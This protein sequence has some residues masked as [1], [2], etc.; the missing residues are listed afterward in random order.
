MKKII[1]DT[2]F[3]VSCAEFKVDLF[4]EFE[5]ICDFSFELFIVDKSLVEL[6]F[7]EKKGGKSKAFVNIVKLFLQKGIKTIK[8]NSQKSVDDLIIETVDKE[9]CAVATQDAE[10]KRRLKQKQ[11]P[12]I[13]IRQKKY[14]ILQS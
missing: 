4:S 5:R 6:D 9:S 2:S 7:I 10:L 1:L 13:T 8:S 14:L 3:L 11:I 12:V